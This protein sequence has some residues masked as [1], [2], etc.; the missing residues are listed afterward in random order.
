MTRVLNSYNI[1]QLYNYSS[2]TRNKYA[3]RSTFSSHADIN[4]SCPLL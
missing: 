1:S 4:I 3:Q 2:T